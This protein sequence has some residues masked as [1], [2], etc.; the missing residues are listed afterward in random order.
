MYN[1]EA[2]VSATVLFMIKMID[3]NLT[4]DEYNNVYVHVQEHPLQCY[5]PVNWGDTANIWEHPKI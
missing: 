2:D 5:G 3:T 4:W 1:N